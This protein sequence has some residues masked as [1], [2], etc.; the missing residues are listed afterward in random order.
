[1]ARA[2]A[3]R[4][5]KSVKKAVKAGARRA[6]RKAPPRKRRVA[7]PSLA[8]EFGALAEKI[9]SLGRAVFEQGTERAGEVA[10][11]SLSAIEEGSEKIASEIAAIKRAA[12]ARAKR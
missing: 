3:K 5:A 8:K 7:R 1:M 12:L 2:K 6:V 4:K 11:A 9:T 10:R